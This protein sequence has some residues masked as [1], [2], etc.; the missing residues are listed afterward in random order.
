M[1]K[2]NLLKKQHEQINQLITDT[3]ELLTEE[4]KEETVKTVAKNINN[5]AG[6][7]KIHLGSEDRFLYPQLMKNGDTLVKKKAKDYAEE[8][9]DLSKI[10]MEFKRKYNTPT[11]INRNS[12]FIHSEAKKVFEAIEERIAK[13][14]HDLYQ[15]AEKL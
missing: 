12:D 11:K 10:F 9:G 4:L 5:L 1:N 14:D 15:L 13:E 8:M 2:L 7:L 3:K 6:K